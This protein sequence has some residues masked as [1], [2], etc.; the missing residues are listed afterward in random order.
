MSQMK[1]D[2]LFI[3]RFSKGVQKSDF[4][5]CL[6][7]F[8]DMKW[9]HSS[10]VTL[11]YTYQCFTMSCVPVKRKTGYAMYTQGIISFSFGNN[12]CFTVTQFL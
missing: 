5:V 6:I 10:G 12:I 11:L 2:L 9:S 8:P 1:L 7:S 4:L 3:K